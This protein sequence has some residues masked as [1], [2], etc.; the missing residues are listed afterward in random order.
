MN[1]LIIQECPKFDGRILLTLRNG[2]KSVS[3]AVGSDQTT[4]IANLIESCGRSA[5]NHKGLLTPTA[6]TEEIKS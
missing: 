6:H 5:M 4:R 1:T 2:N 3:V